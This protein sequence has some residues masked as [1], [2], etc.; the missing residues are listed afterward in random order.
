MLQ[1]EELSGINVS[2]VVDLVICVVWESA[3]TVWHSVNIEVVDYIAKDML[4][5]PGYTLNLV[6]LFWNY[7]INMWHEFVQLNVWMGKFVR[8]WEP[9]I[10]ECEFLIA[11]DKDN[12]LPFQLWFLPRMV[13]WTSLWWFVIGIGFWWLW[14]GFYSGFRNIG[15]CQLLVCT[16]EFLF[17]LNSG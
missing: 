5:I 17:R 12:L 1:S 4:W 7:S 16:P 11:I 8:H 10:K 3:K 6:I 2:W 15:R 13:F 9:N 14:H